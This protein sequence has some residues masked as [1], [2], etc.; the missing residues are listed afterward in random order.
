MIPAWPSGQLIHEKKYLQSIKI[1]IYFYI[2]FVMF[3]SVVLKKNVFINT[4]NLFSIICKLSHFAYTVLP[5][6]GRNLNSLHFTLVFCVSGL[7]V[8][9]KVVIERNMRFWRFNINYHDDRQ[10]AYFDKK[11]YFQT[12]AKTSQN[13]GHTFI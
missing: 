5:F 10:W 8:I 9:G 4:Y 12:L 1:Q 7:V 6:I 3:D 2:L 13:G 11:S